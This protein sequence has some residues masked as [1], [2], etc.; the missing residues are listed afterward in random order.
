MRHCQVFRV[1]QGFTLSLLL[2]LIA[3]GGGG[4]ETAGPSSSSELNS[5]SV[6]VAVD[7][8]LLPLP[9]L[10]HS[11]LNDSGLNEL[12]VRLFNSRAELERHVPAASQLAEVEV[13]FATESL[14]VLSLGERPSGGYWTR[15]TGVQYDRDA[16][17]LYVQ[18]IA[19][20]P[21]ENAPVTLAMTWPSDAAVIPKV[22]AGTLH[23]EIESHENMPLPG[24]GGGGG[25]H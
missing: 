8:D 19:N 11:A 3:A 2:V 22:R 14:I 20:Q 25:A 21:G 5:V 15:I 12:G 23:P 16:D 9:I 17:A 24:G 10:R 18:G 1:L 7:A 4:C 13:D 6:P